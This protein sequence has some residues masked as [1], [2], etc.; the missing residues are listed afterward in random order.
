MVTTPMDETRA[1]PKVPQA[2]IPIVD[3]NI[4][5]NVVQHTFLPK[6]VR[7]S[8]SLAC[9][10]LL[11]VLM[12]MHS[13]LSCF[14]PLSHLPTLLCPSLSPFYPLLF[15]SAPTQVIRPEMC[16]ACGKRIR[17][18]KVAVKCR[19]CRVI[20]HPE[21]KLMCV[22]KCSPNT[23]RTVQP[24]EVTHTRARMHTFLLTKVPSH[25]GQ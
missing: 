21:C 10:T 16:A 12:F 22:E 1:E 17:F 18:G 23:H 11:H 14:C 19:D 9:Q 5:H 15:L 6:T 3:S 8:S 25:N 7:V 20:T 24:S 13:T 2:F 4:Q